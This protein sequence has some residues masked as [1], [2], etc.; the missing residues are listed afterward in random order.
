M[1]LSTIDDIFRKFDLVISNSIDYKEFVGLFEIIGKKITELEFKSSILGK[2][3]SYNNELTLQ[4]FREWFV[5]QTKQE[6]EAKIFEWLNK[7]GYD[8]DLYSVRSRLFTIT[9]HS[10]TISGSGQMEVKIRDAIG[11][12]IDNVATKLILQNYG[13]DIERGEGYRIV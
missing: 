6:G 4:G 8:K 5:D 3:C 9:F 1:F 10:K 13:K 7:L 2:Y 11:T 12:D